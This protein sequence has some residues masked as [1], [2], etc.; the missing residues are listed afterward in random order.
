MLLTPLIGCLMYKILTKLDFILTLAL[1]S[2]RNDKQI[3]MEQQTLTLLKI[4]MNLYV[5]WNS[6]NK[7]HTIILKSSVDLV[8]QEQIKSTLQIK[9]KYPQIIPI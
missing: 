9:N 8:N 2:H 3:L 6:V 5:P 7:E 1:N 4:R